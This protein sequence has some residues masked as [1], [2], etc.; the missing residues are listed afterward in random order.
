MPVFEYLRFSLSVPTSGQLFEGGED[1][2]PAMTRQAF[3]SRIFSKRLDFKHESKDY[4][5]LP[6]AHL[7]FE[8]SLLSGFIGRKVSQSVNA[9]PDEAF[10]KTTAEY[11]RAS[12]F[13]IDVREGE[14]IAVLE[15]RSDVGKADRVLSSLMLGARK[16]FGKQNT[17]HTDIEYITN[18]ESF[19]NVV[20]QNRGSLTK[21]EF[22]FLPSN[23]LKGFDAWKDFD[24]ALKK[25]SNAKASGYSLKNDEGQLEPEGEEVEAAVSYASEGGGWYKLFAGRRL[26][27]Y[28]R[29]A[30]RTAS[31]PKEIMPEDTNS[32]RIVGLIDYLL[33]GGRG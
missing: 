19:W 15:K 17:W 24:K 29:S 20:E 32:L 25:E 31:P 22:E 21:L 6:S 12:F 10:A 30:R 11:Y 2:E 3:L 33:R 23:G 1:R 26:I 18:P 8:D 7:P 27:F 9:G 13:V 4:T 16:A 5:F 28:S 14:Q